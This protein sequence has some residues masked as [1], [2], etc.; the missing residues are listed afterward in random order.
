MVVFLKQTENPE[1]Q[2]KNDENV[3]RGTW[4]LKADYLLSVIGYTVGLGNIWRFPYLVYKNGGGAFLIPYIIMMVLA[5]MPM[6]FMESALGQFASLGPA[7]VWKAVPILQGVGLLSFFA[8]TFQGIY[9]N[10]IVT[11]CLFYFFVSFQTPLPWQE[12]YSWGENDKI[13]R[14]TPT[15]TVIISRM[16]KAIASGDLSF[17]LVEKLLVLIPHR[18][19]IN[20]ASVNTKSVTVLHR[21]SSI[22]ETGKVIWHLAVCLLITWIIV[23][24]V[25]CKGI[26]IS[27]KVSYVAVTVPYASLVLL[28]IRGVTLEGADIGIKYY[29]GS[30]SDFSKLA[31]AQVWKDAAT[32]IFISLSVS[33]G[34]VTALSSYNNFQNDCFTDTLI[35]AFLNCLTSVLVGFAIFSILGHVAHHIHLPVSEVS[36]SGLGLIFLA[37]PEA[38]LHLPIAS[39]WSTVFFSMV[40][41]TGLTSQFAIVETIITSLQDEFPSLLRNKRF[42]VTVAVCLISLLFGILLVTESGIYWITLI[43]HFCSGWG[44]ILIAI[45]ELIGLSWIYGINRFIKDIEMMIGERSWLFWLWWRVC[46]IVVTPILLTLMLIWSIII[47]R[48]PEYGLVAYPSWAITLGW[49]MLTFCF[50][51]VPVIALVVIVYAEGDSLCQKAIAVFRPAPDWGPFLEQ[52]RG[53]QYR[54]QQQPIE[55]FHKSKTSFISFGNKEK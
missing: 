12:C 48:P 7:Q 39:L 28:V 34:G 11:Y 16:Y 1:D 54:R 32:Q 33:P 30:H 38:L 46:W 6:F 9:Y 55:R 14:K 4:A 31:D 51:W 8:S 10:C 21:S 24:F 50:L 47:F 22:N 18:K 36:H 27:G 19:V 35:V 2:E 13:C 45:L 52:H 44:L 17:C 26:K 41:T 25:L 53:E 42:Y 29:I 3:R 20:N 15:G 5:G 37:Y 43:D 40:A 49:L 23:L